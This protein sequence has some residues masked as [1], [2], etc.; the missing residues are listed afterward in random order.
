MRMLRKLWYWWL[1]TEYVHSPQA[2]RN[3]L[4]GRRCP[5][6]CQGHMDSTSS[7]EGDA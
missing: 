1:W 7:S 2:F 3:W 6:W 5:N 4:H